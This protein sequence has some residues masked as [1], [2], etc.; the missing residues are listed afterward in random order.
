MT[1]GGT[2]H[3]VNPRLATWTLLLVSVGKFE[4][5]V[6]TDD[7]VLLFGGHHR[8]ALAAA[9]K[10][11]KGK[12]QLRSRSRTATASQERLHA[13]EFVTGHHWL[14]LSLIPLPTATGIFK[15]A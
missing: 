3:L 6:P 4:A 10:T 7:L 1:K 15:P 14:V 5:T 12:C 11:R 9:N 13:L 2:V 8:A